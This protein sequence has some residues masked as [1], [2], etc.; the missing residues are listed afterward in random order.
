[1]EAGLFR[2]RGADLID[3][4]VLSA[5][6]KCTDEEADEIEASACPGCG[7]CSG[8]F[9]A[10]SM[11]CLNE[12]IGLA[13]PGNG[14]IVA[15]HRNRKALFEKAAKLIVEN[16]RRYYFEGDES[17]L[18]R[19]IA[20]KAAFENAMSLD[21]AMGG[22]T[23]TVLHLLAVAH[24]AGVDFTM[25]DID[26][27]SRKIPV[28]CKVA[29]NGHY[30]VQDVNRAGGIMGILGELAKNGLIDTTAKRVDFASLEEAIDKYYYGSENFSQAQKKKRNKRQRV[31]F[32]L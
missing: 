1:M 16:A 15:T 31:F 21:I 32:T 28:L 6:D 4:M 18:P 29:P 14:T 26:R 27:L 19:S 11:N 9:T 22:S 7:S 10:N 24:E 5:D 23:N 8:M 25:A 20:T 30:H 12:A 17:V 3:A 13:L 2:G